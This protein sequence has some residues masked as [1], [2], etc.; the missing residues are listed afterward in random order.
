LKRLENCRISINAFVANEYLTL[1]TDFHMIN[2]IALRRWSSP[3]YGRW[4]H[5]SQGSA[6]TLLS[7]GGM[8]ISA[9]VGRTFETKVFERV[10]TRRAVRR[11]LPN[12]A[13]LIMSI[14]LG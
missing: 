8:E 2:R 7:Q 11:H 12:W 1:A 14:D 10:A 6:S 3:F 13:G 9:A 5:R 4:S